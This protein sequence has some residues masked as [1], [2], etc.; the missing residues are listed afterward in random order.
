[1]TRE[2]THLGAAE[3]VAKR[4][5]QNARCWWRNSDGDIKHVLTIAY[6][7]NWRTPSHGLKLPNCPCGP[8]AGGVQA[9][10]RQSI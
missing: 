10:G 4:V 3:P 5:A 8:H 7:E 1:M 9:I 2:L 6:F